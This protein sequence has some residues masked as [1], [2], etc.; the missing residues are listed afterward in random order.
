MKY[1]SGVFRRKRITLDVPEPSPPGEPVSFHGFSTAP[2]QSVPESGLYEFWTADNV[3]IHMGDT[4]CSRITFDPSPAQIEMTFVYEAPEHAPAELPDG[5]TIH[6]LF[7]RVAI[8]QW[9]GDQTGPDPDDLPG[10]Q[11][12]DLGFDRPNY[13]QIDLLSSTLQF[14]AQSVELT[15]T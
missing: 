11:I 15:I 12:T 4:L 8:L 7:R 9:K 6:L 3:L 2:G 13:V 5:A 14:T 10:G 1:L